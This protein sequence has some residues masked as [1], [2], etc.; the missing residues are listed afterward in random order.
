MAPT[1]FD[2]TLGIWRLI[3]TSDTA[4]GHHQ[5]QRK[6]IQKEGVFPNNKAFEKLIYLAYRNIHKKWI[7]NPLRK[8]LLTVFKDHI[9]LLGYNVPAFLV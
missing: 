3:Y 8:L 1:Y 6:V 7:A 9:I 4:E 2:N 5:Q